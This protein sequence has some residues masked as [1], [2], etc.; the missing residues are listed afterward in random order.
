MLDYKEFIKFD[1]MVTPV[2]I[3]TLFLIGAAISVLSGLGL[4][5]Q[6]LGARFGGGPIVFMGLI[7]IIVGPIMIRIGCELT[8]IIFK[9]HESLQ[10]IRNVLS[11]QNGS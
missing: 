6:G 11:K 1:K 5:I 3:K 4:I 2:I 9:I 8:I 7:M 10:D